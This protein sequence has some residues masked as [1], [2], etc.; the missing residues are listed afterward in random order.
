MTGTE[1]LP[2][3]IADYYRWMQWIFIQFYQERDW[4]TRK[5]IL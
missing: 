5:R 2:P 3:V 1:K 4:H